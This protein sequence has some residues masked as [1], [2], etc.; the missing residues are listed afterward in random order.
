MGVKEE[1]ARQSCW[2]WTATGRQ[3]APVKATRCQKMFDDNTAFSKRLTTCE[4]NVKAL[5]KASDALLGISEKTLGQPLPQV[6][7]NS[8]DG[9]TVSPVAGTGSP[10]IRAGQL[11]RSHDMEL[12]SQVYDPMASWQKEYARMK[13]RMAELDKQSLRLDS[14]RRTHYK[15]AQKHL[16]ENVMQSDNVSAH[17]VRE[18]ENPELAAARSGY[19]KIESEVH[20]ELTQLGEH[21]RQAQAYLT[22]AMELVA[23]TLSNA[24]A[25]HAQPS[26]GGSQAGMS[27]G[28]ASSPSSVRG[29]EVG[30]SIKGLPSAPQHTIQPQAGKMEPAGGVQTL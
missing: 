24:A 2:C 7:E 10:L 28:G 26:F 3:L 9:T 6:Y 17:A 1:K 21:A 14:A 18:D 4:Q 29:S 25:V 23:N 16:K 20:H 13:L 19:M 5:Q 30:E 11:Q 8:P 15:G 22:R 12:Q 27:V